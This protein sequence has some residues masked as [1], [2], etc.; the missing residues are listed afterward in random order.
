MRHAAPYFVVE[1]QEGTVGIEAVAGVKERRLAD[2][3]A[4]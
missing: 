1:A 2:V 4:L 3:F